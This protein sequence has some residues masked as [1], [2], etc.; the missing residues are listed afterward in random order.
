[1]RCITPVAM[2]ARVDPNREHR[3]HRPW[4]AV[5]LGLLSLD[6]CQEQRESKGGLFVLATALHT[7]LAM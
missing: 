1:M 6:S 3:Q 7:G 2:D 4:T 5:D